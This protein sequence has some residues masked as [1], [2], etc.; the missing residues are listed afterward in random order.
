ME[1]RKYQ[2]EIAKKA[3]KILKECGFVYLSLEV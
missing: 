1:L 2:E 3:T